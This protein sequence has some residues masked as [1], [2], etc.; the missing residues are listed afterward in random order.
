M[1]FKTAKT[2]KHQEVNNVIGWRPMKSPAND[3]K[4]PGG[5]SSKLWVW[6]CFGIMAAIFIGLTFA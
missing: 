5:K 3:N 1:S 2:D 6:I 4:E